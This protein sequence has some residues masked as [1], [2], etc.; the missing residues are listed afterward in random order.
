MARS[1]SK[2]GSS[3]PKK[4][5]VDVLPQEEPVPDQRIV[6][7]VDCL[8]NGNNP[9]LVVFLSKGEQRKLLAEGSGSSPATPELDS[10]MGVG[11]RIDLSKKFTVIKT[12]L[13]KY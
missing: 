7:L 13:V 11:S 3:E 6:K 5:K 10:A 2:L 8:E 12:S 9:R 1:G 4:S